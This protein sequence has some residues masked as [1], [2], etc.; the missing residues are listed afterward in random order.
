MTTNLY[1]SETGE[2]YE[3]RTPVRLKVRTSVFRTEN[4][5]A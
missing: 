5:V 3:E 4:E 1:I 2:P